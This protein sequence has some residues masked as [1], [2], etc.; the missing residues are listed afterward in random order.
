MF[1]N[2][3]SCPRNTCTERW[4]K[5]PNLIAFMEI[6]LYLKNS[7][8]VKHVQKV[9]LIMLFIYF[10]GKKSFHTA[11][12]L[13]SPF[14]FLKESA[15]FKRVKI[16]QISHVIF[17][18]TSQFSF[19]F[20]TN[21]QCHQTQLLCT[22][23]AQTLYTLVKI[24]S[25]TCKFLIFLKCSGQNSSNSSCQFWTGKSIPLQIVHHS[26]LTWHITPL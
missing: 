11:F 12:D 23:L 18:R 1:L 20:R 17:E 25:L 6:F 14:Y 10:Q 22:F 3:P 24:S 7:D 8:S 13:V 15:I 19:K 26:S 16:C 5:L 2:Q 9:L 21:L 4:R